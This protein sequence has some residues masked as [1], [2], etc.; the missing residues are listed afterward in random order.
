MLVTMYVGLFLNLIG[1]C[2]LLLNVT[3]AIYMPAWE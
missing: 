1:L 3:M 2:T